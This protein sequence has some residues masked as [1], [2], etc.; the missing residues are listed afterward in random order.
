MLWCTWTKW[1]LLLSLVLRPKPL[2]A[3]SGTTIEY[4]NRTTDSTFEWPRILVVGLSYHANHVHLACSARTYYRGALRFFVSDVQDPAV[5]TVAYPDV[6]GERS[7]A[8]GGDKRV[9]RGILH[10]NSTFAGMFDWMLVGDDDT[11]FVL[12]NLV[13]ILGYCACS[14]LQPSCFLL[15][16]YHTAHSS[17]MG[18]WANGGEWGPRTKRWSSLPEHKKC[19]HSKN[20]K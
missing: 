1:A 12:S 13:P 2:W 19:A 6:A 4:P 15:L 8:N 20:Q 18:A 14:F 3:A 17:R 5:P 11:Y 9:L 10:A 16:P 7:T